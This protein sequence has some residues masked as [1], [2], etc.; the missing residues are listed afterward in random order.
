MVRYF[1]SP[2]ACPSDEKSRATEGVG[3][4]AQ[5]SGLAIQTKPTSVGLKPLI[6][7]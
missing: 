1:E 3:K 5:R 4:S 2:A 7:G 6:F